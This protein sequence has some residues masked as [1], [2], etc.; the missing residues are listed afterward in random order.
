MIE[1]A[2]VTLNWTGKS[3]TAYE[4]VADERSDETP[5]RTCRMIVEIDG[6]TYVTRHDVTTT[7]EPPDVDR[8][9]LAA[10]SGALERLTREL[11]YAERRKEAS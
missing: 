7:A 8:M 11:D 10:V 6:R 5:N 3:G 9:T 1:R 4:V 2:R